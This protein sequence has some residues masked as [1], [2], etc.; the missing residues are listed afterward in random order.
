MG[1]GLQFQWDDYEV[2]SNKREQKLS[3]IQQKGTKT[4]YY[5]VLVKTGKKITTL[6]KLFPLVKLA[7]D[8]GQ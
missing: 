3:S 5:L 1:G 7:S 8:G 2:A 6:T 4:M